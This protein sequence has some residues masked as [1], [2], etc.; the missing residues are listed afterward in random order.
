MILVLLKLKKA[1]LALLNFE[2]LLMKQAIY[3]F[4]L[5]FSEFSEHQ[6]FLTQKLH[7]AS[8]KRAI[9]DMFSG[10]AILNS[11]KDTK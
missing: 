2:I 11:V 5:K 7:L 4:L 8:R 10:F 1:E 3:K 6:H 9:V